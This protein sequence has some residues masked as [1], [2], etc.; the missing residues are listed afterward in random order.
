[1][2][3]T[4]SRVQANI[5]ENDSCV[6]N[7]QEPKLTSCLFCV[8]T[9][10]N[11]Q[12]YPIYFLSRSFPLQDYKVKRLLKGNS[13]SY[14]HIVIPSS[15]ARKMS[16]DDPSTSEVSVAKFMQMKEH[17]A[18]MMRMMQ[19]LVVG[20]N[21]DSSGYTIKGFALDYENETQLPPDPNQGQTTWPFVP[22]G[23]DQELNIPKD[24]TS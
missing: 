11:F 18:K 15:L 17:T 19:R 10:S 23:G 16:T 13:P 8:S 4:C 1:M 14:H 2:I 6:L 7:K 20:R 22:Q 12:M 9:F 21:R 5:F 3:K 24:K